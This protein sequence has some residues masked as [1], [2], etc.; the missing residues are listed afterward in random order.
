MLSDQKRREELADFIR[1]RRE[2]LSPAQVGLPNGNRYRRTPGLRREEVAELANVSVTWYT[3]LEQARNIRVSVQILENIASALQLNPDERSHL[4]LLTQQ[5]LPPLPPPSKV[6]VSP[7][8]QH[9]LDSLGAIPAYVT[10][11]RLDILAWNQAACAV[12]GDFS[13]MPYRERNLV[14]FAFTDPVARQLFVDWEDFARSVLA[15]F[16]ADCGRYIGEEPKYAD[17]IE[18]LQTV[19]PEFQ[20]LWTHHDV[21]RRSEGMKELNHPIVGRLFLEGIT[22]QANNAP[23]VRIDL[24]TPTPNS[25]TADKLKKL[26]S[27]SNRE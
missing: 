1:V 10:G 26:I 24:Y 12:F 6:L 23:D 19:S 25:E 15:E 17:F 3:W 13:A 8:V 5:S 21:L 22:L 16:R 11:R 4:F 7:A 18:D 14:W 9:I 27:L 2:R 20:Q